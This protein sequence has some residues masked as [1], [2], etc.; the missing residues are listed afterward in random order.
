ML[1]N[2]EFFLSLSTRFAAR[3][4]NPVRLRKLGAFEI[5]GVASETAEREEG[6][7]SECGN[8]P[9]WRNR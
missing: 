3:D 2:G 6:S 1:A 7:M 9:G 4:M 8:Q 5:A